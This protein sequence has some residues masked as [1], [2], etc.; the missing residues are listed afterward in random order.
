MSFLKSIIIN[1]IAK[2]I[3]PHSLPKEVSNNII[4]IA[5]FLILASTLS[6][7]LFLTL[8]FG[9]SYYL[10]VQGVASY[11]IFIIAISLIALLLILVIAM[12]KHTINKVQN[13]ISSSHYNIISSF[14]DGFNQNKD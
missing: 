9:A 11:Q 14:I 1:N 8:C 12:L 3:L 7:S 2:A 13:P 6:T 5:T 4:R 10:F